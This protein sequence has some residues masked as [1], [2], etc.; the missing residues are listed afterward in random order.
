MSPLV[1]ARVLLT[2]G[3]FGLSDRRMHRTRR[4]SFLGVLPLFAAVSC[5]PSKPD[6]SGEM[7][8]VYAINGA[9]VQN[10]C[11]QSA[12]PAV[13]PLKFE[14]EIRQNDRVGYWQTDKQPQ[15]AGELDEDGTFLFTGEQTS[16]VS[17]M[18]TPRNDLEPT[19]FV[20]LTP[21][22]DLKTTNCAMRVKE[23]IEGSLARRVILVDGGDL[24]I[25][26]SNPGAKHD[27]TGDNTIEVS[28]TPESDC[29][30]SLA[31]YGGPFSNLP[32]MAHYVLS[33]ELEKSKSIE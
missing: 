31:A 29:S 10:T 7:V 25:D 6:A 27:L 26:D 2:R 5:V 20:S 16:L 9:L 8:G 30:A 28:A 13:D 14:V 4:P 3:C 32:C 33:G 17:S 24:Q 11:G 18:R 12:L 19:N 21:D 1:R 22:F 15:R 23:T